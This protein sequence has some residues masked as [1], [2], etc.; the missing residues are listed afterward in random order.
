[1][2]ALNNIVADP[3]LPWGRKGPVAPVIPRPS[4][5]QIVIFTANCG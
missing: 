2:A 5:P 1:M 3:V 4:L